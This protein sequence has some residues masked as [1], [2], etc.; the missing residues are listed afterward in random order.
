MSFIGLAGGDGGGEPRWGFDSADQYAT[1]SGIYLKSLWGFIRVADERFKNSWWM[2][3]VGKL[4]G[5]ILSGDDRNGVEFVLWVLKAEWKWM[6]EL[7]VD[8]FYCFW[9]KWRWEK[10][11][12][13]LLMN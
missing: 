11:G 12:L 10:I 8:L 13:F 3:F 6:R 5:L 1:C 4:R 2:N 7:L 9:K